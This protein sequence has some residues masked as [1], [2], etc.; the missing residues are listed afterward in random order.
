M[1][2]VLGG[3][4]DE[5]AKYVRS[6]DVLDGSMCSLSGRKAEPLAYCRALGLGHHECCARRERG[7]GRQAAVR[8][9]HA[10]RK[11]CE[12]A[13]EAV[14]EAR[15]HYADAAQRGGVHLAD[16]R[17]DGGVRAADRQLADRDGG[18]TVRWRQ[19]D[20]AAR[21]RC[22]REAKHG[23]AAAAE[24][25]IEKIA[26][27]HRGGQLGAVIGDGVGVDAALQAADADAHGPIEKSEA[28]CSDQHPCRVPQELA[29]P[30]GG[31]L[32][33]AAIAGCSSR[34]R[35]GLAD[36]AK[37]EF[38]PPGPRTP[39]LLGQRCQYAGGSR[40]VPTMRQPARRLGQ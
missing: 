38:A 33:R 27:N 30:G 37:P 34:R 8:G 39:V 4:P 29:S 1:T 35:G 32:R 14:A 20:H 12:V 40:Y 5:V 24:A 25:R 19:D 21:H 28:C 16:L 31:G 10:E 3:S 36:F 7:D 22:E 23:G 6:G 26:D 2:R 15:K 11:G 17:E 18:A 9:S 13:A